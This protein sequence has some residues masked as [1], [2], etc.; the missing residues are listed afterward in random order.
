MTKK[1]E[2]NSNTGLTILI[3]CGVL[4]LALIVGCI[5]F[6]DEIFGMLRK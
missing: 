5:F 6:P 2:T 1:K 3:I 4:A